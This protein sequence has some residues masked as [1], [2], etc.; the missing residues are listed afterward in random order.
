MTIWQKSLW[1]S[2]TLHITGAMFLN[3]GDKIEIKIKSD[4][5][6]D[7]ILLAES[8][9]SLVKVTEEDQSASFTGFINVR[10]CHTVITTFFLDIKT[11]ADSERLQ[12]FRRRV[13]SKELSLNSY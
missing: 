10:E 9:L 1:D 8:G 4:S 6:R 3:A 13:P 2:E 5:I 11:V 12:N 7:T